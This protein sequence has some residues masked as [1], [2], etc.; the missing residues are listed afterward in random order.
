MSP[1][2][3]QHLDAPHKSCGRTAAENDS[4]LVDLHNQT[5]TGR[6]FKCRLCPES[7]QK[8]GFLR[9]VPQHKPRTQDSSTCKSSKAPANPIFHFV[10]N[11]L[12]QSWGDPRT[13]GTKMPHICGL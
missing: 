4:N 5:A 2:N 13:E 9:R 1:S 8:A 10:L 3:S 12:P 11:C 7:L 6:A